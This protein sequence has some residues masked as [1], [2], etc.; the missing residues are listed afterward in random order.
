MVLAKNLKKSADKGYLE[1][2]KKTEENFSCQ[3]N[4]CVT[5]YK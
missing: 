5:I 1:E 2:Q 4:F 3:V